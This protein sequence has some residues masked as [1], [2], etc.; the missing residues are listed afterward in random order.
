MSTQPKPESWQKI[1]QSFTDDFCKRH[2]SISGRWAQGELEQSF[3]DAIERSHAAQ[4]QH[5]EL[6]IEGRCAYCG[7]DSGSHHPDCK[8]PQPSKASPLGE[9]SNEAWCVSDQPPSSAKTTDDKQ[10]DWTVRRYNH[11]T[12]DDRHGDRTCV[13]VG[14]H[15]LTP[16]YGERGG[17]FED[18]FKLLADA[19]NAALAER[20]R[21]DLVLPCLA[22][23][24]RIHRAFHSGESV[25]MC[26]SIARAVMREQGDALRE[27]DEEVRKPLVDLLKTVRPYI[28]FR[29]EGTRL[30]ADK[31]DDALA[32][33][34]PHYEHKTKDRKFGSFWKCLSCNGEPEFE[35]GDMMKHLKEAHGIDPR[36]TKGS[37]KMLMHMDGDTWFSWDYE[38]GIGAVKAHQHTCQKRSAEDAAYWH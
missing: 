11:G 1:A 30:I 20:Q 6:W 8:R 15:Q 16:C 32:D 24:E 7:E 14:K 21:L 38:W 22:A 34:I 13:M 37:K 4:P 10:K 9:R 29:N 2:T 35:H 17:D 25:E 18:A 31:I 12:D 23:I 3:Y 27:H 5:D 28:D 33:L 19:H 26:Q 36:T